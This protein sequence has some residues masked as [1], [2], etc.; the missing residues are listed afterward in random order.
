MLQVERLDADAGLLQRE[1]PA[2]NAG[3]CMAQQ[4][5]CC[6][7][8]ALQGGVQRLAIAER[9][10]RASGLRA[11]DFFLLPTAGE[12]RRWRLARSSNLRGM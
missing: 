12:A 3:C 1:Q 6:A 7:S 4:K 10:S 8:G 11:R 2:A 5:Q 9:Q